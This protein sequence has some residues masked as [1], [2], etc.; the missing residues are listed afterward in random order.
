MSLTRFG[1]TLAPP[2]LRPPRPPPPAVRRWG[3]N[4]DLGGSS[5]GYGTSVGAD[6]DATAELAV[7]EMS[8]I[9]S[10]N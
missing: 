3:T 2:S 8:E 4:R 6:A 9:E 1:A 10:V 5:A 7:L